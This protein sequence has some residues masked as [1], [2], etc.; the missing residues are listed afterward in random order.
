MTWDAL[1]EH[2]ESRKGELT[3]RILR[4]VEQHRPEETFLLSLLYQQAEDYDGLR[5]RLTGDEMVSAL[6]SHKDSSILVRTLRTAAE[7]AKKRAKTEDLLEWTV[8]ILAAKFYVEHAASSLEITAQLAV[9]QSHE[10]IAKAY[11]VP[12]LS[13]R[14]RLL[15][16]AYS[17]LQEQGERTPKSTLDELASFADSLDLTNMDEDM[18]EQIAVD[19]APILP[20]V[21]FSLLDRAMSNRERKSLF[22]I[23]IEAIEASGK[24]ELNCDGPNASKIETS[25]GDLAQVLYMWLGKQTFP[26]IVERVS[27]LSTT[28]AKEY[29]VRQWCRQ[30]IKGERIVEGVRLWYELIV[31]DREFPILLSSLRNMSEVVKQ[32]PASDRPELLDRLMIPRFVVL[33]SPKEEWVKFRLNLADAFLDVEVAKA[34]SEVAAVIDELAQSELEPD[35][36]ALCLA[37][38]WCSA[39]AVFGGQ[40]PRSVE[41]EKQFNAAYQNLLDNSADHFDLAIETIRT[42]VDVDFDTALVCAVE[43]NTHSRRTEAL[44]QVVRSGVLR[45]G[46][47]DIS[48]GLRVALEQLVRMQRD[49]FLVEL[50][51]ELAQRKANLALPNLQLLREYCELMPDP[52]QRA[53]VLCNLARLHQAHSSEVATDL[54]DHG[55]SAWR[56]ENDLKL[57]LALGFRT[58][59]DL[60]ELDRER[61][62]DLFDEVRELKRQPGAAL[63]ASGLGAF[64]REL[65][66]LGIRA[67]TIQDLED[68]SALRSFEDLISQIPAKVIQVDLLAGVAAAAYRC[69]LT[70]L[71]GKLVR[72]KILPALREI[73]ALTDDANACPDYVGALNS[74]LPVV[75]EY[76]HSVA[77]ELSRFISYPMRDLM[78]YEAVQWMLC[79]SHLGDHHYTAGSL[80]KPSDYPRLKRVVD[81]AREINQDTLVYSAIEAI[82]T[83]ARISYDGSMD[84]VQAFE[85]L[86]QLEVLC[87]AKLPEKSGENFRH[88]GYLVLGRSAIQG[89]KC[90]IVNQAIRLKKYHQAPSTS[91]KELLVGWHDIICRADGIPNVADRVFVYA[92]VAQELARY[93]PNDLRLA[94]QV[95]DRAEAQVLSI[96]TLLDRGDRLQTIATAWIQLGDTSRAKG[97][98][99]TAFDLV[100]QLETLA[101]DDQ[102]RILVQAAHK[103]S[104]EFAEEL[105][106][107]LRSRMPSTVMSSVDI[108]HEAEQL[109]KFPKKIR[110]ISGSRRKVA[111]VT[112]SAAENFLQDIAIGRIV[113]PLKPVLQDWLDRAGVI[114]PPCALAVLHWVTE[115]LR[116]G[117]GSQNEETPFHLYMRG[118]TL[119]Q[120]LA[121]IASRKGED[122]VPSEIQHGFAGLSKAV[123][124]FRS[125]ESER[126]QRWLYEWLEANAPST[127][128]SWIRILMWSN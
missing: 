16:R 9:G 7:M 4:F 87:E 5:K 39:R 97:V 125:D 57:K 44:R 52:S 103:V 80:Q 34:L 21:A 123:V 42:L 47:A 45:L 31:N 32:L 78:W 53:L 2:F 86:R 111:G 119:A 64:F 102:M 46:S 85:I 65:L 41:I 59:R 11:A 40:A 113:P 61:A 107:R 25:F 28:K 69:G 88:D 48:Q 128:R 70:E 89:A 77:Q 18:V 19:L 33:D 63:A 122:G 36:R 121:V 74:A 20:D 24:Q 60:T 14:I 100:R 1:K 114:D 51:D 62:K 30:N 92:H 120:Q 27:A 56:H 83:S 95:L 90:T 109:H 13:A 93:D 73:T 17:I 91:K 96:P 106:T 76:D 55:L 3:S 38:L 71:G 8:G 108:I 84:F 37:R 6:E 26:Q 127:S 99:A 35:T 10:A 15:A 116:T 82:A 43:M 81:A 54:L 66:D 101:A 67:A 29:I 104:N 118:A 94:R 124:S 79:R 105:T 50:T 98:I 23:A 115:C 112:A 22:E 110:D 58:V 72:T 75:T 12:E 49:N 68:D 117:S 126:A